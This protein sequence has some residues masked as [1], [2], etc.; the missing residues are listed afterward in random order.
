MT[1]K[2]WLES[3]GA[4]DVAPL[5]VAINGVRYEAARYRQNGEKIYLIGEIP[6]SYLRRR[7][8]YLFPGDAR[9]WYVASYTTEASLEEPFARCHPFGHTFILA[10]WTHETPIDKYDRAQRKRTRAE[11]F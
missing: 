11:T 10:P 3:C 7:S 9:D 5:T 2:D 6:P 8:L 4:A 1:L